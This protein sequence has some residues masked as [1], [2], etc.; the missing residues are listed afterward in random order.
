[1]GNYQAYVVSENGRITQRFDLR[2]ED[3]Q[4]AI[5]QASSL[6]TSGEIELWQNERLI[7]GFPASG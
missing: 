2:C 6:T 3:D 5:Q 7:A 1:M 4:G